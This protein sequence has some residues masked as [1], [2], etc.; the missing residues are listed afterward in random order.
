MDVE[1]TWSASCILRCAVSFGFGGDGKSL[2][3]LIISR[4]LSA[5]NTISPV[6]IH[7]RYHSF[8]TK[9][10][11]WLIVFKLGSAIWLLVAFQYDKNILL[12]SWRHPRK[13]HS[14]PSGRSGRHHFWRHCISKGTCLTWICHLN[15]WLKCFHN[16]IRT[17]DHFGI[18]MSSYQNRN[19][20]YKGLTI[21]LTLWWVSVLK[22]TPGTCFTNM[23]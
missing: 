3:Y 11:I 20:H 16:V 23:V 12:T 1:L 17:W 21:M 4:E 2:S 13:R 8:G 22:C 19:S 5:R 6:H 15:I 14:N 18:K 7:Q 9:H 10:S